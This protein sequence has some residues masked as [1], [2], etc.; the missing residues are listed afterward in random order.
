MSA[1]VNYTSLPPRAPD[2]MGKV[3]NINGNKMEYLL[4]GI[5]NLFLDL[6]CL[7]AKMTVFMEYN[8]PGTGEFN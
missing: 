4:Y 8:S 7:L 1:W 5:T 2:T 6:S 3:K